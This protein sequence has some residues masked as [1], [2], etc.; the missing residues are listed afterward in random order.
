MCSCYLKLHHAGVQNGLQAV[1]SRGTPQRAVL[2]SAADNDND[3]EVKHDCYAFGVCEFCSRVSM[4]S[5]VCVWFVVQPRQRNRQN[6]IA[7]TALATPQYRGG[8]ICV[9]VWYTRNHAQQRT[10]RGKKHVSRIAM[11]GQAGRR[12]RRDVIYLRLVLDIH[13]TQHTQTHAL[14]ASAERE[15]LSIHNMSIKRN[16]VEGPFEF[17]TLISSTVKFNSKHSLSGC[18][19]RMCNNMFECIFLRSMLSTASCV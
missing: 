11:C 16:I 13:A 9:H 2:S 17:G 15:R 18:V 14:Q 7:I 3:A 19:L 1:L 12:M 8:A 5:Y 6:L 10:K 4:C